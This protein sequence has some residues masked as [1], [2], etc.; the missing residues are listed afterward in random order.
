LVENGFES[1]LDF[2]SIDIDGM[3][4]FILADLT[5]RPRL[6]CIEANWGHAPESTLIVPAEVAVNGI[7]EPLLAFTRSAKVH[8]YQLI[9]YN[10]NA[11]FLREDLAHP[12]LPEIDPATAYVESMGSLSLKDRRWMYITNKGWVYPY[13][14]FQNNYLTAKSLRLGPM[15]ILLAYAW[16]CYLQT[17]R[18]FKR[19]AI[20]LGLKKA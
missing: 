13:Y 7:G 8:G 18:L 2:L 14:K 19:I 15:D 1:P 6:I 5:I 10:H 9:A 3:D 16:A 12:L 11:F 20:A 17:R 4:Y